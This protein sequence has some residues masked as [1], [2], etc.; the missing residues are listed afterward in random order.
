MEKLSDSDEYDENVNIVPDISDEE[1]KEIISDEDDFGELENEPEDIPVETKDVNNESVLSGKFSE[2]DYG[3]LDDSSFVDDSGEIDENDE[4]I[5]E[6]EEFDVG[7]DI[8]DADEQEDSF[9]YEEDSE[10]LDLNENDTT[11]EDMVGFLPSSTET[12]TPEDSQEVKELDKVYGDDVGKIEQSS[13][14]IQ[15]K[16]SDS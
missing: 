15:E 1:N 16:N 8:E 13:S 10:F 4:N 2:E 7:E 3:E 6:E 14:D 12:V 5:V 9:E 11:D